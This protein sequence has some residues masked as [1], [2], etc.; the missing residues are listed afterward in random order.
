M[1]QLKI[2][3][4]RQAG[5]FWVARRFPVQIG[6]ALTADLRSE[7]P[8]VWERHATIGLNRKEGFVLDSLADAL[9]RVNGQ[10]VRKTILHNGD[11]LELGSLTLQFWLAETRQ[12]SLT[13]REAFAWMI[14]VGVTVSQVVLLYWLL[15]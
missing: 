6:R 13:L 8:G 10:P 4:G 5:T 7:A 11:Q 15:R 1:V 2:L 12:A 14:V 3:S 9:V